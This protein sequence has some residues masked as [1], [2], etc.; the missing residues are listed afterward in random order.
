MKK[1]LLIII[2]LNLC[3]Y[4]DFTRDNTTQI[5]TDNATGLQWQDNDFNATKSWTEAIDYCETLTLGSHTDWRLPN[6]NELFSIPDRSK[7]H[8]AIDSTFK[9]VVQNWHWS[10]TTAVG[11]E[12]SAWIVGLVYGDD[13]QSLKSK[14]RYVKCVRGGQ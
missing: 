7:S 11:K 3:V 8:P 9:N 2:G 10:S 6:F 4:A 14:D 5:V 13:D 1:I 12:E